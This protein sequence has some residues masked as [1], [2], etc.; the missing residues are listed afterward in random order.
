MVVGDKRKFVSVLIVPNV[1][2]IEAKARGEGV[3]LMPDEI[4]RNPWVHNL[5]EGEMCRLTESLAQYEKPKRFALIPKDFTFA[6]GE[7]THTLKLK[8]RVVEQRYHDAIES[9]YADLDE[10]RPPAQR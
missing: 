5:I 10:P 8:R 9:L 1:A 2:A 7:L 6:D 4:C 3:G